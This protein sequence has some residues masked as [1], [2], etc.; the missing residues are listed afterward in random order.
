MPLFLCPQELLLGERSLAW[1][2]GG[3]Q[4]WLTPLPIYLCHRI[5]PSMAEDSFINRL[6][7]ADPPGQFV[8]FPQRPFSSKRLQ[9]LK[10]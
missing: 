4:G 9:E 10:A 7:G 1:S 5:L 2:V 6:A 8:A 3:F